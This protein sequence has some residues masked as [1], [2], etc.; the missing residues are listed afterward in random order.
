MRSKSLGRGYRGTS[1]AMWYRAILVLRA[2]ALSPLAILDLPA[3]RGHRSARFEKAA[4]LWLVSINGASSGGLQLIFARLASKS[5]RER[6]RARSDEVQ[7]RTPPLSSFMQPNDFEL[8]LGA[9][10]FQWL[11]QIVDEETCRDLLTR[12]LN[13]EVTDDSGERYRNVEVWLKDTA[14]SDRAF[15][16]FP[17]L[18]FFRTY[19]QPNHNLQG[20]ISSYLGADPLVVRIQAWATRPPTAAHDPG[21][22]QSGMMFHCDADYLNF[23]KLF[24]TLSDPSESGGETEFQVSSHRGRRHVLG[25]VEAT[26]LDPAHP[27]I[28][29]TGPIGSSYLCDTSGWHRAGTPE[30]GIRAVLQIVFTSDLFGPRPPAGFPLRWTE[31]E[32]G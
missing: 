7:R 17:G 19:I 23:V 9:H 10:G 32:R 1:V 12:G 25:R 28:R 20:L 2:L 24:I 5:R 13:N 30:R 14:A 16:D 27:V 22:D 11:G 3:M 15:L 21:N 29:A 8:E 18:D 6:L 4:I 26:S 31:P